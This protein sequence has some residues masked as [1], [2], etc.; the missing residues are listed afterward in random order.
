MNCRETLTQLILDHE[1]NELNS[2]PYGK[3]HWKR[4]HWYSDEVK[5]QW[6]YV[7]W[8]FLL[9]KSSAYFRKGQWETFY[10]WKKGML[11]TLS[12]YSTFSLNRYLE[13]NHLFGRFSSSIV[14]W[15]PRFN[16]NSFKTTLRLSMKLIDNLLI[17]NNG[18]NPSI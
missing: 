18:V 7:Q 16:V 14:S 10:G 12:I 5:N 11:L 9:T 17:S 4:N 15:N 6:I 3:Q 1:Y 2:T 8:L 13:W